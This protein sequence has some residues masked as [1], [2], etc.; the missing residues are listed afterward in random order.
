MVICLERGANDLH[1]YGPAD[2]TGTWSSIVSLKS[3]TVLPY[4]C[5]RTQVVLER[6]PLSGYVCLIL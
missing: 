5:Q 4:W 2:A 6:R 1:N 3:R